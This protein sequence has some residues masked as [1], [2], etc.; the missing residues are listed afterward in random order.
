MIQT[1]PPGSRSG[2]TVRASFGGEC[3]KDGR[4]HPEDL[5]ALLS[6][7]TRLVACTLASNCMGSILDAAEVS[8]R[9]RAAGAKSFWT[10]ALCPHGPLD[11]QALGCDYLVCSGYKTFAPHMGFFG[12]ARKRSIGCRLFGRISFRPGSLEVRSGHLCCT[13]TSPGWTPRSVIEKPWNR[14]NRRS[15]LVSAMNSIRDYEASLSIALLKALAS[16]EGVTVY[17]IA[18]PALVRFRTPTV[19]LT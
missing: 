19:P 17:G 6:R 15:R 13:R 11:V 7:R 8:R 16:I 12:D 9:A 4:L 5:D 18:D 10:G 3:R 1:S 2:P 14:E